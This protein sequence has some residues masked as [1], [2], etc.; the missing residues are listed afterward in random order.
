MFATKSVDL[1]SVSQH[2]PSSGLLKT[3]IFM[4]FLSLFVIEFLRHWQLYQLRLNPAGIESHML[5]QGHAK[6]SPCGAG[7]NGDKKLQQKLCKI[8]S[9]NSKQ[10]LFN[11]CSNW[12]IPNHYLKN[13]CLEF[14][15][16][17]QTLETAN[18]C[19]ASQILG[20][21]A[22]REGSWISLVECEQ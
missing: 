2:A 10:P 1:Q 6:V 7:A 9:W 4:Y 22:W 5:R 19:L 8:H 18:G 20:G 3:G 12:M 14:Q 17:P 16:V 21:N 13:G 15:V 11:G